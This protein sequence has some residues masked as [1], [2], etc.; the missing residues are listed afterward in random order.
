MLGQWRRKR[1]LSRRGHTF[2]F[3]PAGLALPPTARPSH[4]CV[5]G[6]GDCKTKFRQTNSITRQNVKHRLTSVG[7]PKN[8]TGYGA[9]DD[10]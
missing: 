10:K 4:T 6:F 3:R 1:T 8:N 7:V 5:H 9:D 2:V